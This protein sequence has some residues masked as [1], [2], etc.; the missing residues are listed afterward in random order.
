MEIST[1]SGEQYA[2][3]PFFHIISENE[4]CEETELFFSSGIPLTIECMYV[5]I[6]RNYFIVSST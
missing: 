2:S 4:K 6:H 5:H 3:F 1:R